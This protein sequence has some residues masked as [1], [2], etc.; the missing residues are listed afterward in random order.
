MDD[1]K[2]A[3]QE[4]ARLSELLEK[5]NHAYYVMDSPVITDAEYDI[6][7]HQLREY[8]KK[9]PEYAS[10][11]SPTARV[12]GTAA[13]SPVEHHSP[14]LSLQDVF[15]F[16]ELRAFD[17]RIR[18]AISAPVYC[19]E[20]KVDGL[21]VALRYQNGVF[22]QAAT[23]GD[24]N[25]GEDVTHNARVIEDIPE[26]IKNAPPF[27]IVRAEVYMPKGS[28]AAL[29]E[30]R[31]AESLPLFA[32][33]R[34]AAAGSLRQLDSSST[35]ERSLSCMVFNIQAMPDKWFPETHS[36]TL[37]MLSD[38]GF[39]A[40]K[41][42][43]CLDVEA[44]EKEIGRLGEGRQGSPFD[45]DGAVIKL[46]SLAL[47][48][49]LGNTS[50]APRWAVAYKYPPERAETRVKEI[51]IQVGR[52][53]VLTPK[54]CLEPVR[55]A[56]SVV[57]YAT[58]HNRDN[59]EKKD[60]RIG[61]SVLVQKAGDII[62]EIISVIPGKRPADSTP[63]IFPQS[64]PVCREPVFQEPQEA[65]V[66]C[67]SPDCP[68][69]II[70]RLIHF[71]SRGAMDIEGLGKAVCETLIEKGLVKTLPDIY[72]LKNE[73]IAGLQGFGERSVSNL[74]G[75][76]EQSKNRGLARALFGL[77]IRN[78]GQ[79]AAQV[80]ARRFGSIEALFDA[81]EEALTEIGDIGSVI[82]RSLLDYLETEQA[83]TLIGRLLEA[84][85]SLAEEKRDTS[86]TLQGK[87]FVMTGT[88]PNLSRDEAERLVLEQGGKT[89]GSVSKKTDFVIAGE[90]AG[91]KLE[92]ALALGIKVLDERGF[93]ELLEP[94]GI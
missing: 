93:L 90:S 25:M 41:H 53:G 54:A 13:F 71:A 61:D 7:M 77:G 70:R 58:L 91:S 72:T 38:W 49:K 26:T 30:K 31:E 78:V 92:K 4:I 6:A 73:D 32:N 84:G 10:P 88:L 62:P 12:G 64:C 82:A 81:G 27:L 79:K 87:T 14:M 28:F 76:I 89:A 24:G 55:L 22:A 11:D 51:V 18:Q 16:D 21:S 29:N 57:Q 17:S 83:R 80:I 86:G 2:N 19:V 94:G 59:I 40:V 66:R 5:A 8:E 50:R 69:Q 67:V 33:P 47:R 60:I 23:R 3:A 43:L 65:A 44:I 36:Q 46:D 34:N 35:A 45:M 56:G 75:A 15:D 63:Y 52:T 37:D 74:L 42:A 68:A 20:P 1:K 9:H 85:V 48:E 39:S